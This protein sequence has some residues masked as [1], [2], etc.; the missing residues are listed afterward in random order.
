MVAWREPWGEMLRGAKAL[1]C[2]SNEI[3]GRPINMV[4]P[5]KQQFPTPPDVSGQLFQAMMSRCIDVMEI[6]QKT[7]RRP[8]RRIGVEMRAIGRGR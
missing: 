4:A 1:A 6:R 5:A 8:I 3:Y 2:R 7:K